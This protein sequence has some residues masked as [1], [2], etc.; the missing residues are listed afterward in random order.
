MT[1]TP[2]TEGWSVGRP[3]LGS[4]AKV[5]EAMIS[6]DATAC[7]CDSSIPAD[8]RLF[9]SINTTPNGSLDKRCCSTNE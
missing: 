1:P 3:H 9:R 2:L 6:E 8:L 7:H 4:Y 5:K